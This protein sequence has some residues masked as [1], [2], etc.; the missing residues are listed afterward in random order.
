MLTSFFIVLSTL[1]ILTCLISMAILQVR[2]YN[3]TPPTDEENDMERSFVI[4]PLKLGLASSGYG[5][6]VA[7]QHPLLTRGCI[8]EEQERLGFLAPE[9]QI[10]AHGD[11]IELG[12]KKDLMQP[13]DVLP[14]LEMF[15]YTKAFS[16]ESP[17][18]NSS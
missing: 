7:H 16:K 10:C 1:Q 18:K 13:W 15:T 4:T 14:S 17:A 5:I 11:T 8:L 3:S 2:Y 12:L 9:K 6:P